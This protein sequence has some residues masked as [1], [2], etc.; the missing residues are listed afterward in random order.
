[1]AL[2]AFSKPIAV[3]GCDTSMTSITVPVRT[4]T[5]VW[6]TGTGSWM[7]AVTAT[8]SSARPVSVA[9]DDR[10][11]G[12]LAHRPSWARRSDITAVASPAVW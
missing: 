10:N 7:T 1:V 3:L 8:A 11:T 2:I 12:M 6:C 9:P 5:T 4:R